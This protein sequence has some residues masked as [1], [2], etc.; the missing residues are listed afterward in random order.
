MSAILSALTFISIEDVGKHLDS[1]FIIGY[2]GMGVYAS[3]PGGC[4]LVDLSCSCH[5]AI[6]SKQLPCGRYRGK[7]GGGRHGNLWLLACMTANFPREFLTGEVAFAVFSLPS[8]RVFV[9]EVLRVGVHGEVTVLAV[10]ET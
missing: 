10:M 2:H 3:G 4:V 9:E 8:Q 7:N 1:L 5:A 6:S